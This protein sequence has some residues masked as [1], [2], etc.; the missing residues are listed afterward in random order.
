M[1][2]VAMTH[3]TSSADRSVAL[4]ERLAA[5]VWHLLASASEMNFSYGEESITDNLLLKIRSAALPNVLVQKANKKHEARWGLDWEWWIGS[6][7]CG[8]LRYAV[9]AKK[10]DV[11][12]GRY[13]TL[14]HKIR[15]GRKPEYQIERL[16]AFSQACRAIPIYCFYNSQVA[17]ERCSYC[18]GICHPLLSCCACKWYWQGWCDFRSACDWQLCAIHAR[19][20]RCFEKQ[21]GCTIANF[22]TVRSA[23]Q[24]RSNKSFEAIHTPG[25][26]FPWRCLLIHHCR[27]TR[28]KSLS[29]HPLVPDYVGQ[30]GEARDEARDLIWRNVPEEI[31]RYVR[32]AIDE[33]PLEY[34]PGEMGAPSRIGIVDLGEWET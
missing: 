30:V 5:E 24:R 29:E 3:L 15:D 10:L 20:H 1:N 22:D 4:F 19:C 17:V 34:Y 27:W 7:S 11:N 26:A 23:H 33:L 2:G 28:D 9:Q 12:K 16:K 25:R 8:W 31:Q 21:F 18:S 32:G 6:R 14:R 13:N